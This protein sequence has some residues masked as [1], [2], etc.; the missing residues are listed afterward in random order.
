MEIFKKMTH[1]CVLSVFVTFSFNTFLL[2]R[3]NGTE[4]FQAVAADALWE[5]H[6]KPHFKCLLDQLQ[7]LYPKYS[8]S[9]EQLEQLMRLIQRL[10][11]ITP[12]LNDD[13]S[14]TRLEIESF[15]KAKC[16]RTIEHYFYN[17]SVHFIRDYIEKT[18]PRE[19][20][21]FE[22]LTPIKGEGDEKA[23]R[24]AFVHKY[25]C[26]VEVEELSS[27]QCIQTTDCLHMLK[28]LIHEFETETNLHLD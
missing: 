28:E 19:G 20:F 8:L 15:L 4:T 24:Y 22:N 9:N 23:Y 26:K 17:T 13:F 7:I 25:S 16:M 21:H 3:T 2:A 5:K 18:Y 14:T 11:S 6:Y 10:S 12:Q 1:V 27:C